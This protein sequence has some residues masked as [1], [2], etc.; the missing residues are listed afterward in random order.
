[1]EEITRKE[2]TM[3]SDFLEA[4]LED[5]RAFL[6]EMRRQRRLIEADI[7]NSLSTIQNIRRQLGK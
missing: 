1:M 2:L 4:D 6:E 3:F 7:K 5:E